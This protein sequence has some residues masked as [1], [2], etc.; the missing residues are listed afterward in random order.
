[1]LIVKENVYDHRLTQR[2]SSSS[3]V[4]NHT[5]MFVIGL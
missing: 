5:Q 3:Y 4:T 2:I 1:M